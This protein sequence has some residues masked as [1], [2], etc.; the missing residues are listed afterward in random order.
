MKYFFVLTL[1]LALFDRSFAKNN[2]VCSAANKQKTLN[3]R[4]KLKVSETDPKRLK[5][6]KLEADL[7]TKVITEKQFNKVAKPLIIA[8]LKNTKAALKSLSELVKNNPECFKD[9]TLTDK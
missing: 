7:E 2:R 1:V 5:L 6:K 4:N 9:S 3:I 8:T